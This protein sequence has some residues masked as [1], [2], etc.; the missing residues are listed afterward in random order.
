MLATQVLSNSSFLLSMK[1]KM[2]SNPSICHQF[3]QEF[4]SQYL[5]KEQLDKFAIQWYKTAKAHKEAFPSLV[6]N[7]FDDEIRFE[8]IDILNEE[9]GNGNREQMHVKLLKRFLYALD[10]TDD[11]VE[12]TQT[13]PAIEQ[14]SK[15]ILAIWKDGN[16]IYAFG[17]HFALEFLAATFH[18]YFA[19][20]LAKYSFL[21]D[22]DR[23]YF[24][25]HKVAEQRHSDFS[26]NGFLFSHPL[27]LPLPPFFP[28]NLALNFCHFAFVFL[29]QNCVIL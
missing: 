10:I 9:Y 4:K 11:Q 21:S 19:N 26:E 23:E 1:H 27:S 2:Q 5:T 14:F 28:F 20:G 25:Y 12:M 16:S 17:L 6:Y 24:N 13:L 29:F 7:T 18:V 8:L 3:L 15:E 22:Y